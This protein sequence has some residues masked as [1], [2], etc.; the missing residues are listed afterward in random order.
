MKTEIRH[1][2]IF[3]SFS[4][5]LLAYPRSPS[6]YTPPAPYSRP[7]R[8]SRALF[9]PLSHLFLF[10]LPLSARLFKVYENEF[11]VYENLCRHSG[12]EIF[13][14]FHIPYKVYEKS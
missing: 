6:R 7:P 4:P 10:F 5:S 8:S 13:K 12:C 11:K 9:L 14:Y 3:S 2:K 1:M